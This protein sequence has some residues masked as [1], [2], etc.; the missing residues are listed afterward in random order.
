[1]LGEGLTAATRRGLQRAASGSQA[2]VLLLMSPE[3][4]RR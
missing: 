4:Q 2:L 1:M 3:F